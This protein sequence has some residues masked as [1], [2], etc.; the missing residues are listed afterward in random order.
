MYVA[1]ESEWRRAR[2]VEIKP[3]SVVFL[4]VQAM[5]MDLLWSGPRDAPVLRCHLV[6]QVMVRAI[7]E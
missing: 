2:V 4:K 7:V 3:R 5:S 6:F 1:S